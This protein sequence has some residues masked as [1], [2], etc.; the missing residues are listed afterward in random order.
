MWVSARPF[1]FAASLASAGY[2][3]YLWHKRGLKG[4]QVRE[5]HVLYPSIT[6]ASLALAW[7]SRPTKP[8]LDTEST[9]TEEEAEDSPFMDWLDDKVDSL[10]M[11]Y[12]YRFADNVMGRTVRLHGI[13]E[14]WAGLPE[15]AQVFVTCGRR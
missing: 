13:R 15:S 5:A 14:L 7:F 12:G 11:Q 2:S 6:V 1:V 8:T 3:A 10:R 9:V 4:Q